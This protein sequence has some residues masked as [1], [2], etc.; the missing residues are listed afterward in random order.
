MEVEVSG[1]EKEEVNSHPEILPS[2]E[3]AIGSV[4]E[5]KV[6]LIAR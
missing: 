5:V 4:A 3:E 1:G 6:I 2:S